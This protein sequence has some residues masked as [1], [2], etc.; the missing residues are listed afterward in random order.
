M[1]RDCFSSKKYENKGGQILPP[2]PVASELDPISKPVKEMELNEFTEY[3]LDALKNS[4]SDFSSFFSVIGFILFIQTLGAIGYLIYLLNEVGISTIG[5]MLTLILNLALI[6]WFASLM[7]KF[8]RLQTEKTEHDFANKL[9]FQSEAVK[10]GKEILEAAHQKTENKITVNGGNAVFAFDN[11]SINGVNQTITIEG[12]SE[13]VRS[14][15]LL[16][17]Y[18]EEKAND[19]AV[20][21][22]KLLATEA[23]KEQP[24]KLTLIDLWT[25]IVSAVP[26]VADVVEIAKDIKGLF[27]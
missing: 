26:D 3:Y 1:C 22:S 25:S 12:N 18:C 9:K 16:V 5:P 14:L 4:L 7:G 6:V 15:A 11:S 20:K 23:T 21:K 10:M 27:L 17:S 24:D 19:D 13:L 8:V 2:N